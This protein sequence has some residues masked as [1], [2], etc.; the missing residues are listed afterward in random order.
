MRHT[1][2]KVNL[3]VHVK[4]SLNNFIITS[5]ISLSLATFIISLWLFTMEVI[6]RPILFATWIIAA[7]SAFLFASIVTSTLDELR[8]LE[9]PK[10]A[11]KKLK[12]SRNYNQIFISNSSNRDIHVEV[13]EGQNILIKA[14]KFYAFEIEDYSPQTGHLEIIKEGQNYCLLTN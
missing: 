6:S 13:A 10:I 1:K 14:N 5:S 12:A 3:N 11:I 8:R 7:G 4:Q 9:D 2:I